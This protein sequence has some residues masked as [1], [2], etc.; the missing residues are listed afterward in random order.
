M[1]SGE[2]SYL[3]YGAPINCMKQALGIFILYSLLSSCSLGLVAIHSEPPF[4]CFKRK[5]REMAKI[6]ARHGGNNKQTY[7]KSKLLTS[8][9]KGKRHRRNGGNKAKTRSSSSF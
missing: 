3:G 6:D 8:R 9:K 2:K 4:I 7:Q 1:T 5:C